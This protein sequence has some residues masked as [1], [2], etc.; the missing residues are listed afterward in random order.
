MSSAMYLP[1][2][3]HCPPGMLR[4]MDLPCDE[5][6]C[7]TLLCIVPFRLMAPKQSYESIWPLSRILGKPE[8]FTIDTI[9]LPFFS[10]YRAISRTR[11][12][13]KRLV[14]LAKMSQTLFGK[15]SVG[16]SG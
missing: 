3:D 6:G 15:S 11:S 16:G 8:Q 2:R 14:S 1:L 5:K 7:G 10:A 13:V 12:G 4:C 9:A